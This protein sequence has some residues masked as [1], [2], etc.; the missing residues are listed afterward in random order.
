MPSQAQR[1]VSRRAG[2][3]VV[4]SAAR[5]WPSLFY[6]EAAAGGGAPHQAVALGIAAA[7]AGLDAADAALV[8][9]YMSVTTPAN[10]ALRLLG[11]DPVAV[12]TVLAQLAAEV[13]AVTNEAAVFG[14]G[15]L[16]ALPATA[17]PSSELASE[18][19]AAQDV[20][21]FVS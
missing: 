14:S 1:R 17:A 12:Q 18:E 7:S 4:R 16:S 3:Q 5:I 19:H 21:L 2:R 8:L 11:L 13:Q 20:R 10:A 6:E 15:P 9:A